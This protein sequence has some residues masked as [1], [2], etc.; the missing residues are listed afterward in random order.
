MKTYKYPKALAKAITNL[1]YPKKPLTGRGFERKE[2][3]CNIIETII[4]IS[5]EYAHGTRPAELQGTHFATTYERATGKYGKAKP[6]Y[7]L[8]PEMYA[9]IINNQDLLPFIG[10]SQ[11]WRNKLRK[12]QK[13]KAEQLRAIQKSATEQK[14]TESAIKKKSIQLRYNAN[15]ATIGK[16]TAVIFKCFFQNEV[17][18]APDH[19]AYAKKVSGESWGKL[20]RYYRTEPHLQ[21]GALV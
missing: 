16:T 7:W 5:R 18:P 21:Q 14:N 8:S 12:E 17:H 19:I 10:L 4:G 1:G 3:T 11:Y 15:N 9:L 6:C 2:T 13:N 20:R